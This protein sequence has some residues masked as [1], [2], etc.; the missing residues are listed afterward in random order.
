MYSFTK[1]KLKPYF[2][3]DTKLWLI[4]ISISLGL[5]I[6][7]ALFLDIKAYIFKKDIKNFNK[8]IITLNQELEEIKKKKDFILKEKTIYA[9]IMVKNTLLKQSIKN[10]L[11]L[12]PDPITLS[13][14]EFDK[15]KLIIYGITPSKD[16][17]NLLML[18][19]LESIF[20][21][22]HTYFYL[23]P[24]GWYRFKSENYIKSAQ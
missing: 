5:Y 1:P 23:M 14:C 16:I 19:P 6:M 4:F 20:N 7:F 3:E 17:Y 24:N 2:Q 10:L 13:A 22:T 15:N 12:I 9:D 21:E 11:D 18:P 8:E